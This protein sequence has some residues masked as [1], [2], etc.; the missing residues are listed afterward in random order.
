MLELDSPGLTEV[1]AGEAGE[2]V[3]LDLELEAAVEPVHE[4]RAVHIHGRGELHA[5][6]V[7]VMARVG[8]VVVRVHGEVGDAD[9]YV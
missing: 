5:E 9:L 6:P 4:A 7:V 8:V 2:E 3:V 1:V